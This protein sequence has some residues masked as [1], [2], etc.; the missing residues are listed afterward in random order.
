MIEQITVRNFKSIRSVTVNL[1]PVTVLIGRSGT[2]K[3]N[4][5]GAIDRKSVV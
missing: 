5:L 4:F 1:E 2:G 3:S